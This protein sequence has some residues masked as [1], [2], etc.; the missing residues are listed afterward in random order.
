MAQKQAFSMGL[1]VILV[2]TIWA[3]ATAQSTDCT[4]VLVSM[5]PCLNYIS[6]S[7]STPS[8]ACCTQL[9]TVVRAQPRC[10]CQVLNG[11]GSNLGLNINKTQALALPHACRVQTPP[12]SQCNGVN[13]SIIDLST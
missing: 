12:T 1:A 4:N 10:L 3:N 5:S 13:D 8:S 7:S 11:G 9:G 2:T 6:G